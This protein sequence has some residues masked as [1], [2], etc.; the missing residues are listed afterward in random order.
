MELPH[1]VFIGHSFQVHQVSQHVQVR[2]LREHHFKGGY[3]SKCRGKIC[4]CLLRE[5]KD[6]GHVRKATER[7]WKEN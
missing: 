2:F 7:N 6:V 4:H 3:V 1:P 5:N